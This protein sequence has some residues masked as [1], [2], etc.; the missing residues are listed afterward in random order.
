MV[1]H[2]H[3]ARRGFSRPRTPL[4]KLH[5]LHL[6]NLPRRHLWARNMVFAVAGVPFLFQTTHLPSASII[7]RL[8]GLWVGLGWGGA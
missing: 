1:R 8:C 5:R 2:S 7:R 6:L 3:G 4:L